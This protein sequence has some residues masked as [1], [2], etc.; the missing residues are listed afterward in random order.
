MAI[1]ALTPAEQG[2]SIESLKGLEN[3]E[4]IAAVEGIDDRLEQLGLKEGYNPQGQINLLYVAKSITSRA[5]ESSE[6]GRNRAVI[7]QIARTN[8]TN[9]YE[10]LDAVHFERP[11]PASKPL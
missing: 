9:V 2:T 8:K 10:L 4:A 3:V 5:R 7:I 1:S 11:K 6:N